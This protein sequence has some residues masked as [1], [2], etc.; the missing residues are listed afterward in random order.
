MPAQPVKG[1]VAVHPDPLTKLPDLVEKLF[2]RHGCE[3]I[4]HDF[5]YPAPA[6]EGQQRFLQRDGKAVPAR[7]MA[8]VDVCF[9]GRGQGKDRAELVGAVAG[10]PVFIGG[11]GHRIAMAG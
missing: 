11:A 7:R 10:H 3:I 2:T 6:S 8:P 9:G 1:A 5:C 4:I